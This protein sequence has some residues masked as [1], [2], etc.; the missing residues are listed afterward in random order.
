M[1]INISPE[2]P[3]QDCGCSSLLE[4][5]ESAIHRKALRCSVTG[6]LM[7]AGDAIVVTLADQND[8]HPYVVP[9]CRGHAIQK[10]GTLELRTGTQVVNYSLLATCMHRLNEKVAT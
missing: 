6:C 4:H 9:V 8:P 2:T 7:P 5:W 3:S 10:S 1:R